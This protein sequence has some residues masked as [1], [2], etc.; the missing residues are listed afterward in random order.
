MRNAIG[1]RENN[2][3]VLLNSVFLIDVEARNEIN[4]V[5][6]NNRIVEAIREGKAFATSDMS[7]KDN[8]IEGY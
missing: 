4:Y 5:L 8:Q 3:T 6:F 2:R 7:M 1:A